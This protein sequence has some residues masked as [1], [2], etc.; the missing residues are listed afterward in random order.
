MDQCK[1]CVF[2]DEEYDLMNQ[3]D[4]IVEGKTVEK[5]FCIQYRNGI[6]QDI[7]EDVTPC[8]FHIDKL[9]QTP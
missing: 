7:V 1:N 2:Y 4:T 6:L 8:D 3:P 9:K 5:H